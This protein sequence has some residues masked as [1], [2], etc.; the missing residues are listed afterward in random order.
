VNHEQVKALKRRNR[1]LRK[2]LW[3][4]WLCLVPTVLG[5]L[6]WVLI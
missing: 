5:F 6:L 3:V 2:A 1:M 4:F